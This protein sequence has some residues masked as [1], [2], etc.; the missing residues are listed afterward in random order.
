MRAIHAL[1]AHPK[2]YGSTFLSAHSC[3]YEQAI[4]NH[5]H[6][7]KVKAEYTH[8]AFHGNLPKIILIIKIIMASCVH[9]R[10]SQEDIAKT[11]I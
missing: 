1:E 9:R 8:T 10:E 11:K 3:Q 5:F 7:R 6:N 4:K 2:K